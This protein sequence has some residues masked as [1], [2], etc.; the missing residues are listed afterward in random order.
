MISTIQTTKNFINSSISFK[1]IT[2]SAP[3]ALTNLNYI[4]NFIQIK[5]AINESKYSILKLEE[6][7][8]K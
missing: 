7:A 6:I 2:K 8:E 5:K 3:K 4:N 1:I